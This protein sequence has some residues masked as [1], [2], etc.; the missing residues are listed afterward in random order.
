MSDLSSL[1]TSLPST[2]RVLIL[3]AH[4]HFDE[5]ATFSRRHSPKPLPI[6]EEPHDLVLRNPCQRLKNPRTCFQL[7]IRFASLKPMA[8]FFWR[9]AAALGIIALGVKC[10]SMGPGNR[11][12]GAR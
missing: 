7:G 6:C 9:V 8:N 5:I 10:D 12:A 1:A 3:S 11:G 4:F 2:L